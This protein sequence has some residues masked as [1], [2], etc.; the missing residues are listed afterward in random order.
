MAATRMTGFVMPVVSWEYFWKTAA[1]I[2]SCRKAAIRVSFRAVQFAFRRMMPPKIL[3]AAD[4]VPNVEQLAAD[5]AGQ[6]YEI[7]T[8]GNEAETLE[9]VNTFAPDLILLDMMNAEEVCATL[10]NDSRTKGIMILMIAAFSK[11]DD[12]ERAVNA[13]SDDFLSKPLNKVDLL[14]RVDNMLRLRSVM[15]N[16]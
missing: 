7:D 5:F 11:L 1:H 6:N 14:K 2:R 12:I 4:N 8:A 15:K 16:L 13:G 3:I 10:K 9:K